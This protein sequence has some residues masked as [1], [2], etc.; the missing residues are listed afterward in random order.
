MLDMLEAITLSLRKPTSSVQSPLQMFA[1][2]VKM[3]TEEDEEQ[4]YS[5]VENSSFTEKLL[6]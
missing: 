5:Q 1:G 3:I 4:G 6:W 2:T